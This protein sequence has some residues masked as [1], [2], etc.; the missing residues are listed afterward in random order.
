MKMNY[1]VGNHE[2][3]YDEEKKY[4]NYHHFQIAAIPEPPVLLAK[5]DFQEGPVK[6]VGLNGVSERDLLEIVKFRLQNFQNSPFKCTY[7]GDA[8]NA[9]INAIAFLDARTA[10]RERRNVEGYNRQ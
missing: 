2:I 10:D 9:V 5:I 7:N 6:E 4:N 8:L 1:S 3:S